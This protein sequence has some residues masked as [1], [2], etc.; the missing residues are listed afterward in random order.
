MVRRSLLQREYSVN[1]VE[2]P[3]RPPQ[4]RRSGRN[5]AV[6]LSKDALW[7][8]VLVSSLALWAAIWAGAASVAW[9]WLQ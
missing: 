6:A 1:H 3:H 4:A 8:V 5:A 7:V 2:P 9:A